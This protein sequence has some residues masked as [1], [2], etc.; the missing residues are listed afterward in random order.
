MKGQLKASNPITSKVDGIKCGPL[1][2]RKINI[3]LEF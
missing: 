2:F 3:G 1:L